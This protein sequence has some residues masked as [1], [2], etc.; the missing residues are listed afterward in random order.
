[1]SVEKIMPSQFEGDDKLV[2]EALQA[3][4]C[5]LDSRR[6][7]RTGCY[8]TPFEYNEAVLFHA[9]VLERKQLSLQDFVRRGL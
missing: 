6:Y 4:R 8:L 5:C 2:A 1:M 9:T 3:W 7:T